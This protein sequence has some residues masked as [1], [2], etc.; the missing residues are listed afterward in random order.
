MIIR[1]YDDNQRLLEMRAC[2]STPTMGG[3]GGRSQPLV[4][5]SHRFSVHLMRLSLLIYACAFILTCRYQR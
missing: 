4:I 3:P 2:I 5:H 1:E